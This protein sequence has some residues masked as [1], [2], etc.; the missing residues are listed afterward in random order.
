M[1]GD[2]DEQQIEEETL[3]VRWFVAGQQEVEVL[4]ERQAT[5]QVAGEV[6]PAHL[7]PVGKDRLMPVNGL[8]SLTRPF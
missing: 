5:H 4:G 7:Y 8:G 1:L 3:V 6:A 2:R